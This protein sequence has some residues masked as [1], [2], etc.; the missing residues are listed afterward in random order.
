MQ[1]TVLYANN[2]MHDSRTSM[3]VVKGI[4][5]GYESKSYG[6]LFRADDTTYILAGPRGRKYVSLQA[7]TALRDHVGRDC[8]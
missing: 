5:S 3:G 6:G 7:I 1:A 4:I 2:V 8:S